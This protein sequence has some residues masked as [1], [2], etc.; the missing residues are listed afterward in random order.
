MREQLTGKC[1]WITGASSGIGRALAL[2]LS[3]KG[4]FVIASARNATALNELEV[5][6]RGKIVGLPMDVAGDNQE[7]DNV[8]EKLRELTDYV[9]LVVCCAGICEYQDDLR[10]R[11]DM[12]ER[13]MKINFLGVINVLSIAMPLLQK[14]SSRA[15][16]A[17][18]GS[19]SSTAP[20]PRAEAYGAS[21]AA[22]EYFMKS[23]KADVV[24]CPFDVSLIRP[25][26]IKTP[27]TE[28]NDFSMPFMLT[29]TEAAQ[30]IISGIEAKKSVID[31]P[32]RLS[33]PLRL[34]GSWF[35]L[36]VRWVAP[37]ITRLSKKSWQGQLSR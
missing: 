36:W 7:L 11:P 13:V 33:I 27:L 24:K 23:L 29:D 12:Y 16:F 6:H 22:L 15:H 26:F 32:K 19:L 14:S 4:N 8:R 34:F 28:N 9:D 35:A 20:F 30:R 17:A 10:F 25:G 18:V 31:F 1:I 21:K 2:A 37:K 5:A 3:K